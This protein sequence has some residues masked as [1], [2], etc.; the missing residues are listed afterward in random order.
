MSNYY[1]EIMPLFTNKDEYLKYYFEE[2]LPIFDKLNTIIKKGQPFQRQALIKNLIVYEKEPLFKSLIN[3]IIDDIPTWDAE[4]VLLLPKTLYLLIINTDYILENDLFNLIFK[5]MILSVSS[6]AEKNKNEYTFYFNKIIEFYSIIDINDNNKIK[7]NFFP[8]IINDDIIELIDSLGI[9]GQ[10]AVNRKLSCYLSSSLCRIMVN[11]DGENNNL[12]TDNIKRLYK[13]LSYLFCDGDKIIESQM[14]RELL[15]IIPIFKDFMFTNEDITQAIESYINH[16][17]DHIIQ[18]MGIISVLKNIVYLN[19]ENV[20]INILLN[21][22]KEITEDFDYESIYKNTILHILINGIYNNYLSLNPWILYQVFQLGIMKNYYDFYKLDILFIKNFGKYYFLIS[23]F[24]DKAEFLESKYKE[25]I[26]NGLDINYRGYEKL[27]ENIQTSLNF[28]EYF[29]KIYNELFLANDNT[30]EK[31]ISNDVNTNTKENEEYLGDQNNDN[32]ILFGNYALNSNKEDKN[33]INFNN[34]IFDKYFFEQNL[35]LIFNKKITEGDL[36]NN[37]YSR[38]LMR[39]T[40]YIYIPKII[41]CFPNLKNNKY[42]CDKILSLFDKTNIISMLN[43]YSLSTKYIMDKNLTDNNNDL[44]KHNNKK[45]KKNPLYELML[46]L[47]KKNLK[48]FLQQGKI[49]N[50]S[51]NNKEPLYCEGNIYNKL[52][53]VILT[54]VNLI[55]QETPNLIENESHILIGKLLKLLIPKFHKYYKNITYNAVVNNNSNN[56]NNN[57]NNINNSFNNNKETIK[58]CYFEKIYEELFNKFISKIIKN[59]NLGHHVIKEYIET[60]PYFILFS[61]NRWKYYDFFIKEIFSSDSF[62]KRKYSIIFYNQCFKVF[63]FGFICKN[64]LLN[65]FIILMKDKVNLI[66]TNAIELIYN[67]SKKIIC[68]STK[69]FQELCGILNDIYELNI[70][71]FNDNESKDKNKGIIFDKEKNIIINKIISINSNISKYYTEEE[72]SKEKE[73]E[74]KLYQNEQEIFKLDKSINNK[75]KSKININPN[76]I[77]NS[78]IGN[79]NS[80]NSNNIINS[81]NNTNE[82]NKI[83]TNILQFSSS[84]FQN[85]KNTNYNNINSSIFPPHKLFGSMINNKNS[86]NLFNLSQ[87]EKG[88]KISP[89]IEK[90]SSGLF[91]DKKGKNSNSKNN[92]VNFNKDVKSIN[93]EVNNT[94][95]NNRHNSTS[96]NINSYNKHYLPKL[97]GLKMNRKDLNYINNNNIRSI[98]ITF[99]KVNIKIDDNEEKNYNNINHNHYLENNDNTNLFNKKDYNIEIM[100]DKKIIK[101]DL[102][103]SITQNRIPSAKIKIMNSYPI[104]SGEDNPNLNIKNNDNEKKISSNNS[105]LRYNYISS[106]NVN[107]NN[108]NIKSISNKHIN[109]LIRPKSKTIKLRRD[110]YVSGNAINKI[111]I[112]ANK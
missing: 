105:N 68:Y 65:D 55:Y 86:L 93:N 48:L 20:I 23:Y 18:V 107:N 109:M 98:D 28:E 29:I 26:D 5:H 97:S 81:N 14:A 80:L 1:E 15:Y 64:G 72:I 79:T 33:K 53:L 52:V 35:D 34:L 49:T 25:N 95:Y 96:K 61:K 112:D 57:S 83:N 106:K 91:K 84:N 77:T 31:A 89:W 104:M 6:G 62:Y 4:T 94:H 66:S 54:N 12:N 74:N 56:Q 39:K 17:T 111:Y 36:Y 85:N 27:V 51:N 44:D 101:N 92:I 7:K 69:K 100:S 30:N 82:H 37:L 41:A 58:V 70:K 38:E 11:L 50:K 21:K 46:F 110:S 10:T 63:S 45:K 24:L 22:I 75:N 43:I 108:F 42:L 102:R 13:R 87:K 59:N 16:D 76:F 99:N 3:F 67:F 9:F 78:S 71:A 19:K 88:Y 47:L 32:E 73:I 60:I 103:L 90:S 2:S 40:L 8:Y